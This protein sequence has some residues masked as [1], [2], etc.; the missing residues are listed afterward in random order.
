M[1]PENE[2]RWATEGHPIKVAVRRTGLTPHAIRIWEKRYNAVSPRRTA[3]NRRLYSDDDIERLLLLR[4]ATLAGHNI[5]QVANVPT[6][7]L[8]TLLDKDEFPLSAPARPPA[9]PVE[10]SPQ[11]H[12]DAALHA[13]EQLNASALQDALAQAG[14]ALSQPVLIEQVVTPLM[15]RI[16]DLWQDGQL[17]VA[18]EHLASSVVRTFLGNRL[19]NASLPASAPR[20]IVATP[21]GQIHELG[22]LIV[23]VTAASAGWQITYLGA[24]LPTEE[25]AGAAHQNSARAVALSLIYPGNDPHL[26]AE[27]R[28]LRQGLPEGM[29]L[30]VGG[31]A[32]EHYQAVLDAIGAVRIRD[33]P[34]LR[35]SL[36]TLRYPGVQNP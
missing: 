18:H 32:T 11:P 10:S 4:R 30:L 21:A 1:P 8:R 2:Y 14:V 26:T 24:D 33:L 35:A 15:R 12:L 3:T 5:G 27:L 9:E 22:A 34:H 36:V 19:A 25:I 20:L 7:A 17:R 13:V 16:G 29:P 23:A 28:N 6:D 31:R